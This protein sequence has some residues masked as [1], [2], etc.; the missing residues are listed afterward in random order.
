MKG[1][2]VML[3][4]DRRLKVGS[5][6]FFM[7]ISAIF[8]AYGKLYLAFGYTSFD[9]IYNSKSFLKFN[10]LKAPEEYISKENDLIISGEIDSVYSDDYAFYLYNSIPDDIKFE[11]EVIC[12]G[13][14]VDLKN[15]KDKYLD[16]KEYIFIPCDHYYLYDD[17]RKV[18]NDLYK[19][20]TKDHVVV[21]ID[22]NFEEN[23][24]YI[25]DKFYSFAGNVPLDKLNEAMFSEY[26]TNYNFSRIKNLSS[27]VENTQG[28]EFYFHKNIELL[29]KNEVT[30]N[31]TVYK[32]NINALKSFI[33]DFETNV[34]KIMLLKGRYAPQFF[35]KLIA[36]IIVQKLS[37]NN[38]INYYKNNL[39]CENRDRILKIL[40]ESYNLWATIDAYNDKTYLGGKVLKDNLS[41]YKK[42]LDKLYAIEAETFKLLNEEVKHLIV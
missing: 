21:L 16:K 39:S 26:R 11:I 12:S 38:L 23:T 41:K 27:I 18:T 30:I 31:G 13:K 6:C 29:N 4:I 32:K 19:F 40:K 42:L 35:S 17:Y 8:E 37:Y 10:N 20:H 14:M 28:F 3:E 9:Y 25:I 24:A 22:I 7:S 33:S 5:S 2:R 36:R 34:E 15:I 1:G